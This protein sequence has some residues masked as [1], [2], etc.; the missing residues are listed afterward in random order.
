MI[1]P[2]PSKIRAFTLFII[3]WVMAAV[4]SLHSHADTPNSG[5]SEVWVGV[6]DDNIQE[7]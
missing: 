4:S 6:V 7:S 5:N 3:P 2:R 1:M